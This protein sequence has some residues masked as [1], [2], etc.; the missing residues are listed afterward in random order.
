MREKKN[1]GAN[2]PAIRDAAIW[3]RLPGETDTQWEAFKAYRDMKNRN[4]PAV[5]EMLGHPPAYVKTL[6]K[7]S[8]AKE[9]RVRVVAYDMH[10]DEQRRNRVL[11]HQLKMLD[12][13]NTVIEAAMSVLGMRLND[14]IDEQTEIAQRRASGERV[15]AWEGLSA[16]QTI[17]LYDMIVKLDKLVNGE[18]TEIVKQEMSG[19]LKVAAVN[20]NIDRFS[21]D[22]DFQK[23]V[24]TYL[25]KAE[26]GNQT[27]GEQ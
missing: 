12:N 18:P 27:I 11:D 22:P 21:K 13:H 4:M 5:A 16:E 9:W 14:I 1:P 17:K 26:A 23:L 15:P 19:T 10:L 20:V 6:E 24:Q 3:K 2:L 8:T 7:W 25:E